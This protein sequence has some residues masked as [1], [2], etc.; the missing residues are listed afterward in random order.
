MPVVQISCNPN[1]LMEAFCA[2]RRRQLGAENLDCDLALVLEIP[3][4]IDRSHPATA[5]FAL[6]GVSVRQCGFQ[7]IK[8]VVD[9]ALR[10]CTEAVGARAR[11]D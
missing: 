1:L 8:V 2:Q 4:E 5:E 7:P 11:A 6:D 3:S 10:C 9:D